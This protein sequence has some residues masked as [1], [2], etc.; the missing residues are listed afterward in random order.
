MFDI[1]QSYFSIEL[2]CAALLFALQFKIKN[3]RKPFLILLTLLMA[4]CSSY[5]ING[6]S[7]IDYS[8][9][10]GLLHYLVILSTV[11][12]IIWFCFSSTLMESVIIGIAGFALQ[13]CVNDLVLVS[14]NLAHA[15]MVQLVM[16]PMY[17]FIRFSIMG[18][19]YLAAYFAFARNFRPS[20][21]QI[22]NRYPWLILSGSILFLVTVL[23]GFF[24]PEE[25]NAFWYS[26][27]LYDAICTIL[28][29]IILVYIARNDALTQEVKTI[30]QILQLKQEQYELSKENIQLINIKCHDIRKH[31]TDLYT[32][33]TGRNSSEHF[34][35]EVENSIRIY[36]SI[37]RTGNES[38]DVILTEKILFCDKHHIR[39]T[40]MADGKYLSFMDEVD[41]YSLFAN[42][43]DN[44]IESM[45]KITAEEK[46]VINLDVRTAGQFLRI[47]EENYYEGTLK[48]QNGLPV[49]TKQ[50]KDYHG[51]GMKSIR[52]IVNKYHGE[53]TIHAE[54]GI[55]SLNILL[56]FQPSHPDN[57]QTAM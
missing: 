32:G 33:Q 30:R 13:H 2:I 17:A 55:F 42:I 40:C 53:M 22:Q 38:L 39:M 7:I 8:F 10:G 9:L 35:R 29:L 3:S 57:S 21:E 16:T 28:S 54:D 43:L 37:S 19:V 24:E 47:Q 20:Q 14:L 36:D 25:V 46:R 51:F 48:F 52:M 26:M 45:Q 44:A 31:I 50:D 27:H 6:N 41:V 23:Y 34:I 56:P 18:L 15:D 11:I 5:K 12:A 1:V 49:T 4:F